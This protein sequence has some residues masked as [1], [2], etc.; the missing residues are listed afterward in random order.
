[1]P[2]NQMTEQVVYFLRFNCIFNC[3]IRMPGAPGGQ[4]RALG[5]L[6]PE[7]QMTVNSGPLRA[8]Q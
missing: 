6:E 3:M 5:P 8:A 1:M 2:F 7:L 4:K